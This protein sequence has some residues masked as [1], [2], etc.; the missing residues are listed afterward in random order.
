MLRLDRSMLAIR[1]FIK[2]TEEI[3]PRYVEP[4][5]DTLE[6]IYDEMVKEIPALFLLSVGADPTDAIIQLCRKRK[7][8]LIATISMGEGQENQLAAISKAERWW[9]GFATGH[10]L[11]LGSWTKWKT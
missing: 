8:Q 9:L 10:E 6:S 4:V 2:A 7:C 3:G 11:G 5:T 1:D